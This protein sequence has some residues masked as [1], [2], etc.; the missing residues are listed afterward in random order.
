[1]SVL[2]EECVGQGHQRLGDH[3][4]RICAGAGSNDRGVQTVDDRLIDGL[5]GGIDN[6]SL[7]EVSCLYQGEVVTQQQTGIQ[8]WNIPGLATEYDFSS[9]FPCPLG[10]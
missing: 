10:S 4:R 2:E 3:E 5:G 6:R 8:S 9:R 7:E 1:M